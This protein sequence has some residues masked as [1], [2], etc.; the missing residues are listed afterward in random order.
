MTGHHDTADQTWQRFANAKPARNQPNQR[1]T[2]MARVED[3]VH[4]CA[5]HLYDADL[6]TA[7]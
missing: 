5:T 7:P 4:A 6:L 2:V 1:S 3:R